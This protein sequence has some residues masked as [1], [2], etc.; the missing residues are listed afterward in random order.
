MIALRNDDSC[1]DNPDTASRSRG[2]QPRLNSY[3]DVFMSSVKC[4]QC[5][6]VNFSSDFECRRCQSSLRRS[7][8]EFGTTGEPGR[9]SPGRWVLWIAGV[10]WLIVF[11]WSRSLIF[12]SEPL[13]EQRRWQVNDA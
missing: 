2:H 3:E 10:A 7:V 11:V 5:G 13:E 1:A 8:P 4:P 12:T 9:R 6:L